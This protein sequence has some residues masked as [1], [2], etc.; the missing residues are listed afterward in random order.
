ME[1]LDE[2]DDPMTITTTTTTT[3]T[4]KTVRIHYSFVVGRKINE[5][6]MK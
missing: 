1:H 4:T 2:D 3:T 5:V 6:G